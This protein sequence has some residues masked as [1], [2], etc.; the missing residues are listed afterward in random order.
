VRAGDGSDT[1]VAVGRAL[2]TDLY[3]LTMA[4]SYLR[5]AM[6]GPATFSLFVRRLPP[7]RGFLVA[8]G[9]EDC[10]AFLEGFAFGRDDLAW[11]R[12]AGFDDD[13]VDAFARLRFTGDVWAMPEGHVVLPD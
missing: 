7:D 9:I 13:A 5:R 6:V 10:L 8:A 3:E 4:A 1:V 11:L 2:V 12:T